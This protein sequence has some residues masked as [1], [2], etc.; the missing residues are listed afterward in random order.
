MEV[1]L[2]RV[3]GKERGERERKVVAR[4][5][6]GYQGNRKQT[7]TGN[8]AQGGLFGRDSQAKIS[9]ARD[10]VDFCGAGGREKNGGRRN[11]QRAATVGVGRALGPSGGNTKRWCGWV[12]LMLLG[13]TKHGALR[14]EKV[15]LRGGRTRAS[16][17]LN[18]RF[19]P[20]WVVVAGTRPGWARV[21]ATCTRGLRVYTADA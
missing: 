12:R 6:A 8:G 5:K 7:I 4:R 16:R 14:V 15:G 20:G 13:E 2:H 17:D 1:Q 9:S 18:P 19:A 21:G 11:K 3:A 10:Q